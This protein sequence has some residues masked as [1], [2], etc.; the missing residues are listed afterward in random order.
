ML[1]NT[2]RSEMIR[3]Y[4]QYISEEV[5]QEQFNRILKGDKGVQIFDATL[6]AAE[7][8]KAEFLMAMAKEE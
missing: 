4:P 1:Y 6:V 8:A 7:K 5:I 2:F 3:S